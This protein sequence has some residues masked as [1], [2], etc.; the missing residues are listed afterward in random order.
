MSSRTQRDAARH[1]LLLVL[2]P[3]ACPPELNV[4]A[5]AGY[6]TGVACMAA[7]GAYAG[8]PASRA[9]C[10]RQV[11]GRR[12]T[13]WDKI[14]G[15]GGARDKSLPVILLELVATVV[16]NF[17]AGL[18][19]SVFAFLFQAR[20]ASWLRL[21]CSVLWLRPGCSTA[22]DRRHRQPMHIMLALCR[23]D[24]KLGNRC[25]SWSRATR[26][27]LSMARSFS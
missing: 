14:F 19:V 11:F 12:P 24:I 20:V 4:L 13:V 23:C 17:T 6:R 27:T 5:L 22:V 7:V 8:G 9:R 1:T 18:T 16:V 3:S 15:L 2:P 21:H 26:P 10:A 25:R